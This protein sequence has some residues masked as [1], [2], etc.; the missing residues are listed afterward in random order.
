MVAY[1]WRNTRFALAH[2]TTSAV[3]FQS[4]INRILL[5]S[6][7]LFLSFFA[8]TPSLI[9][10]V[11][12]IYLTP[13]LQINCTALPKVSVFT[14]GNLLDALPPIRVIT[15]YLATLG[16]CACANRN[17]SA[18]FLPA[19]SKHF[20]SHRQSPSDLRTSVHDSIHF[21]ITHNPPYH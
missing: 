1:H 15:A 21:S 14:Q 9:D 4:F 7:F 18:G 8:P 13:C 5:F 12:T 17:N 19:F 11:R 2:V 3:E 6:T 10:T 20:P 16:S